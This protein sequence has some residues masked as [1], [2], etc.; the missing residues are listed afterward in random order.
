MDSARALFVRPVHAER[1]LQVEADGVDGVERGERV[2]EHHLDAAPVGQAAPGLA[3]EH[4]GAAEPQRPSGGGSS[5]TT[6]RASVLLP[7]PDSPTS[8]TLSP[9][10][11][12]EG[13]LVERLERRAR[14]EQAPD[15]DGPRQRGGLEQGASQGTL[16]MV[17]RS[18][19]PRA[20]RRG[21][22]T[23]PRTER[24]RRTAGR[25]PASRSG[26]R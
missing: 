15:G 1:A 13:H 12:G 19:P 4:V 26:W 24:C 25:E 18:A 5:R 22:G 11:Q 14:P 2:L 21:S 20:D 16:G 7:H 8:A 9:A 6:S 3:G 17:A 10:P 23:S